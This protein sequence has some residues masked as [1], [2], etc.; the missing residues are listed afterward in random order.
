MA[1]VLSV[2]ALLLALAAMGYAWLL[3]RELGR[4]ARRL[5]RYNRA[6]FDANDELRR[7][8]EEVGARAAALRVELMQRTGT[9]RFEGSTTVREAGQMHPQVGEVLAGFHLGGC[10]SCA[11]EPDETLAQ[12]AAERGVALDTLLGTLNLL[13]GA[14]EGGTN[15][16]YGGNG[17]RNSPARVRLPNVSLDFEVAA[18]SLDG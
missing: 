12:V 14:P 10:S 7:L 15:G 6:L 17:S 3:Q 2:I 18:P 5:D 9:L 16:A 13:V 11:V 1:T 4:A 8:R